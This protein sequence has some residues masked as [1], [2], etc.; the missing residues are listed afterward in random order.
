[1]FDL[2]FESELVMHCV[3]MQQRFYGLTVT[4]LKSL[5]FQVAERNGIVHPFSHMKKLA[6]KDWVSSFMR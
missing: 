2:E 1:V 6:G 3:E 4:D 5:A